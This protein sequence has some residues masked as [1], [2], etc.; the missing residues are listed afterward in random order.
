MFL[1]IVTSSNLTHDGPAL[2]AR[3]APFQLF[4]PADPF[5]EARAAL[6][7]LQNTASL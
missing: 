5:S 3:T 2:V 1:M 4:F 7:F 6:H